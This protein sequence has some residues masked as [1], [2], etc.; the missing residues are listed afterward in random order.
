M[1]NLSIVFFY[2]KTV[3]SCNCNLA[4]ELMFAN[5]SQ[6]MISYLSLKWRKK[7]RCLCFFLATRRLSSEIYTV[8]KKNT[9][10]PS[11]WDQLLS[12]FVYTL[13]HKL[14]KKMNKKEN[15]ILLCILHSLCNGNDIKVWNNIWELIKPVCT[16]VVYESFAKKAF[17]TNLR[18]FL[19]QLRSERENE[20]KVAR[21]IFLQINLH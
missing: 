13:I 1:P 7:Q 14:N 11:Q 21:I 12:C 19:C 10:E 18:H 8:I 4:I 3:P 2:A 20:D 17:S 15:S 9:L 5:R 16:C 6:F